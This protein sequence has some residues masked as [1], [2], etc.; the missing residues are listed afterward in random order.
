VPFLQALLETGYRGSIGYELCSPLPVRDG[1]TVGIEFVDEC[2][3]LAL[4]FMRA[5]IAEAKRGAMATS[6]V[7]LVSGAMQHPPGRSDPPASPR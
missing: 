6:D 2:T 7:G 5:T 3:R 1:K 4:E